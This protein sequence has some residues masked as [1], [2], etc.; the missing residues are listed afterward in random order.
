MIVVFITAGIVTGL[1]AAVAAVMSGAG[2]IGA[3]VAYMAFSILAFLAAAIVAALLPERRGA[4]DAPEPR[5]RTGAA[6]VT[7]PATP[8][9][10]SG[11]N[12]R[13]ST[14]SGLVGGGIVTSG[15]TSKPKRA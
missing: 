7:S 2:F 12:A 8:V 10:A 5:Y 11:T 1:I 4:H 15:K 3:L 13:P 6:R 14:R 9:Q